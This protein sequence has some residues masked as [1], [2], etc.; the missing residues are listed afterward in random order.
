MTE[1]PTIHDI[2]PGPIRHAQLTPEL[3][4]RIKAIQLFFSDITPRTL[5]QW[6]DGFQRDINPVREIAIW[7]AIANAL[8]RFAE[9]RGLDPK[10]RGE[11]LRLLLVRSSTGAQDTLERTKRQFL[12]L[13]DAQLLLELYF[14]PPK[15]VTI[16]CQ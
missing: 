10:A 16:Y 11:A 4:D 8:K 1:K 6:I 12:S 14:A 7:E 3:I 9:S 2:K 13:E 5:D 15:P